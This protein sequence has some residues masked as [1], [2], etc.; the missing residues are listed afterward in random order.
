M[1]HLC[2]FLHLSI[3]FDGNIFHIPMQLSDGRRLLS[4]LSITVAKFSNQC[5]SLSA[6]LLHTS[7]VLLLVLL[8]V[9]FDLI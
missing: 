4:Q 7:L 5:L 9:K 8:E 1:S 2:H 3:N 6:G